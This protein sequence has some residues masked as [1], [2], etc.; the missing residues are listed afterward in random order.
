[1]SP[2]RGFAVPLPGG[3]AL[4]LG[5]QPLLMGAINVTPDS[6]SDGGDHTTPEAVLA[7][8]RELRDA[9]ADL[10]DIGGE[11]TRPGHE[12]VGMQEELDRVL[13]AVEALVAGGIR[14]PVSIDT[15]K[16]LVADQAIQMGAA[17]VNDVRGLQRDPEMADVATLHGTPVIAMHWDLDRDT[18]RDLIAEMSRFFER[19]VV[20]ADRAGLAHEKLILDPGFGFGKSFAENYELLRRLDELAALGFPLLVGTSRKSMFGKLLGVPPKERATATA[21]SSVIAY[22]K[23]AHVFRVHDLR[24]NRDALRVAAA[25]LYGPPPPI[26]D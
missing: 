24:A 15:M 11:S 14:L 1:M 18:S 9:G 7:R 26:E 20:I 17:V 13:P 8:A 16:P 3:A 25:T 6:F 22:M 12:P 4:A 5:P 10:I 23:G 2:H 19:T 21:A